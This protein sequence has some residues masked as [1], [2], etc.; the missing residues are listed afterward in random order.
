MS[1]PGHTGGRISFGWSQA[2]HAGE[3]RQ[4]RPQ[5]YL[6]RVNDI[7]ATP[8]QGLK[9]S[10]VRDLQVIESEL[11]LIAA[12]RR[13]AAEVG[14]PAPRIDVADELLDE[15]SSLAR[16]AHQKPCLALGARPTT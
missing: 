8:P 11:R 6:N 15:W 4:I 1:H 2:N 14:A 3:A 16:L 9:L 10:A 12:V 7:P 5:A 13:T